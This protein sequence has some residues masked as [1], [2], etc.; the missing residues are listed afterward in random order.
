MK[1]NPHP[2]QDNLMATLSFNLTQLKDLEYLLELAQMSTGGNWAERAK[3]Y[4]LILLK[5]IAELEAQ[6]KLSQAT[7]PEEIREALK[8][9]WR[10]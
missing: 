10:S 5:R 1:A 9:S 6:L 8:A 7:G 3:A 4:R 2:A